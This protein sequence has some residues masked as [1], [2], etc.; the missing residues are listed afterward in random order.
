MKIKL[1]QIG[2]SYGIRL[3]K[4]VIQECHLEKE[5]ELTIK[6][7]NLILSPVIKQRNNWK[8]QLAESIKVKPVKTEGEWEW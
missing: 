3:P 5:L 8:E 2:N 6:K 7:P 4:A 1:I